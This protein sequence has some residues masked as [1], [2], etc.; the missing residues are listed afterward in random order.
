MPQWTRVR[1][2][3]LLLLPK[4]FIRL[5]VCH[6]NSCLLLLGSRLSLLQILSRLLLC[7]LNCGTSYS[8]YHRGLRCRRNH[9]LHRPLPS[10]SSRRFC[11]IP[12]CRTTMTHPPTPLYLM[13]T[14]RLR[15]WGI[16][17]RMNMLPPHSPPPENRE[18]VLWAEPLA[19]YEPRQNESALSTSRACASELSHLSASPCWGIIVDHEDQM[20]AGRMIRL[21]DGST[22]IHCVPHSQMVLKGDKGELPYWSSLGCCAATPLTT[23]SAADLYQPWSSSGG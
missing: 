18:G 23:A 20:M 17:G 14:V 8:A 12:L 2:S 5:L 11:T 10:A 15:T 6:P 22:S 3:P 13:I 19:S 9:D 21:E 4:Q 7:L 16:L 1:R